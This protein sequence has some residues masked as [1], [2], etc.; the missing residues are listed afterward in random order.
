MILDVSF[1]LGWGVKA[2]DPV[3]GGLVIVLGLVG[4]CFV[5]L[6]HSLVGW[7]GGVSNGE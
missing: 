6:I 7:I 3:Y 1:H 5:W 4:F 2:T